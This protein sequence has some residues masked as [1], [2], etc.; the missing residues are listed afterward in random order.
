MATSA[1]GRILPHGPG[2]VLRN[3][4]NM[5]GGVADV[6]LARREEL[7]RVREF[8]AAWAYRHQVTDEARVLVAESDGALVGLVRLEAEHGTT[9]LRGMRV[10]PAHQ[11]RGIGTALLAEAVRQ[12]GGTPCYCIPYT[13]LLDFYAQAGFAEVA[14]AAA[15]DFLRARV[16]DYRERGLDVIL[17]KR[18]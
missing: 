18:G 13:H 5:A 3:I 7:A 12:L 11:R 8:L 4:G 14:P 1:I 6:R 16:L 17:M 9:V 2:A 10:D 15:P